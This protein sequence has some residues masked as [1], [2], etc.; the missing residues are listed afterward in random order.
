[1]EL[2]GFLENHYQII[3]AII[4]VSIGA[5][6]FFYDMKGLSVRVKILEQSLAD[7]FENDTQSKDEMTSKVAAMDKKLDGFGTKLNSFQKAL[8][9][10]LNRLDIPDML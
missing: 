4:L 8:K 5:V 7:N 6:K 10:I 9:A 1:M 3:A 2:L